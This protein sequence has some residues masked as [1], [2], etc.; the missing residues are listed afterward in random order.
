MSLWQIVSDGKI[1]C[2]Q[3]QEHNA[4]SERPSCSKNFRAFNGWSSTSSLD[5]RYPFSGNL[6]YVMLK[7][8]KCSEWSLLANERKINLKF[9][10]LPTYLLYSLVYCIQR[11]LKLHR[12]K[13]TWCCMESSTNQRRFHAFNSAPCLYRY[14][15]YVRCSVNVSDVHVDICRT[16]VLLPAVSLVID[17]SR[18]HSS[19]EHVQKAVKYKTQ[20]QQGFR[21]ILEESSKNSWNVL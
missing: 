19:N 21:K 9:T 2:K 20:Q 15:S 6:P 3:H 11:S 13:F 18:S 10:Y 17:A 5:G 12:V 16:A 4:L 7:C 14:P 8:F 1:T